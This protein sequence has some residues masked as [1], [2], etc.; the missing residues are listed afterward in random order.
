MNPVAVLLSAWLFAFFASFVALV[1]SNPAGDVYGRVVLVP[2]PDCDS[3]LVSDGSGF[4]VLRRVGGDHDPAVDDAIVG[5]LH[6]DG[7]RLFRVPGR[8]TLQAAVEARP[9]DQTS[10]ERLL[11]ER[12][13]AAGPAPTEEALGLLNN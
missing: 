8:G 1:C 13:G 12:C 7:V 3:S 9:P 5:P 6:L 11:E 10:A 2:G 4:L